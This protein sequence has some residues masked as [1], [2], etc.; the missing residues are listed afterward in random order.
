[1]QSK[2]ENSGKKVEPHGLTALKQS[3]VYS[4]CNKNI[5]LFLKLFTLYFLIHAKRNMQT[6]RL[7]AWF[8]VFFLQWFNDLLLLFKSTETKKKTRKNF[9][10]PLHNAEL[11]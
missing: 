9:H 5:R 1:M 2:T 7:E 8:S 4:T 11:H 6:W 10:L 3:Y